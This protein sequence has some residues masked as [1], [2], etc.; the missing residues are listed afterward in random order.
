MHELRKAVFTMTPELLAHL[1]PMPDGC[2]IV[3]VTPAPGIVPYIA[4]R[5]DG[6]GLPEEC[7]CAE[8]STP[9]QA[10]CFLRS[11]TKPC[12]CPCTEFDRFEVP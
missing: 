3:S 9:R 11:V 10:Q 6:D 1:L 12:G 4:V 7:I 5:V 2:E 8:G